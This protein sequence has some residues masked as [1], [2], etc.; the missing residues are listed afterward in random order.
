MTD[1]RRKEMTRI[2]NNSRERLCMLSVT[3]K[4][5]FPGK[6][7]RLHSMS[8]HNLFNLEVQRFCSR[9]FSH[10]TQKSEI[11][12]W[13]AVRCLKRLIIA[14]CARNTSLMKDG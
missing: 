11:V 6:I 12:K 13:T 4:G 9:E 5:W 2:R 3:D 10:M 1:A 7:I 8:N 14:C